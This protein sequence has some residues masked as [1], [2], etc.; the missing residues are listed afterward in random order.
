MRIISKTYASIGDCMGISPIDDSLY[1]KD[2]SYRGLLIEG[3][4]EA[5][6]IVH[7][8]DECEIIGEKVR[9]LKQHAQ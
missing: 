5:V 1:V 8:G 2:K 7:S 4:Y 3:F 6:N 9:S